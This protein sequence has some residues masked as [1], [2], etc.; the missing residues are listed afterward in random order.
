[1][2]RSE[3]EKFI[4]ELI[5]VIW[6]GHQVDKLSDFYHSELKGK[7]NDDE[8]T[9]DKLKSKVELFA[10]HLPNLKVDVKDLLIEDHSF[11]LHAYQNF[12]K[13]N[14]DA[15]IHTILIAHLKDSKIDR[16]TMKTETPI[17]FNLS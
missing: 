2:K 4:Y 12:T 6:E 8:V 5:D 3:I 1:M 9:F 13:E 16:Y 11:A 7:Y 10:E 14:R 17:D 15:T